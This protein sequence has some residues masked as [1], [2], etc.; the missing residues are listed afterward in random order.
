VSNREKWAKIVPV[1]QAYVDGKDVQLR[2]YNGRWKD[3]EGMYS[4]LHREYRV[5]PDVDPRLGTWHTKVAYLTGAEPEVVR[6]AGVLEWK[7][8]EDEDPPWP[9]TQ[10]TI[11]LVGA[12]WFVPAG[13]E[14]NDMT[15]QDDNEK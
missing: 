13:E 7:G 14:D 9:R 6:G 8:R 3:A 4:L 10:P 5:K 2:D 1:L 15:D 12:P 11:K